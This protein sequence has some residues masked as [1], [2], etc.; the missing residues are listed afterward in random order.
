MFLEIFV[1]HKCTDKK[2]NSGYPIIEIKIRQKED[3]ENEIIENAGDLVDEYLIMQPETIRNTAP[4]KF[5]GFDKEIPFNK[6]LHFGNFLLTMKD[7]RLVA[8]CRAITCNEVSNFASPNRVFSLSIPIDELK[9]IDLYEL[10]MAKAQKLGFSVRDCSL[11]A[12]YK[13]PTMQKDR[14]DARS[15]RLLNV[16]YSFKDKEGNDKHIQNP[17]VSWLPPRCNNFDKS[18]QA[19]GCRD[20]YIDSRRISSLVHYLDNIPK[21]MWTDERLLPIKPKPD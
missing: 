16:T 4:I 6:Y 21:L 8:D 7:S 11:C 9:D 20:Y 19:I 2:I 13:I 14:I 17:Y 12:R 15:C 1:T 3:A 5:Y 18:M 10:G